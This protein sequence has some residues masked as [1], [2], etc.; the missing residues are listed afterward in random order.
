MFRVGSRRVQRLVNGRLRNTAAEVQSVVQEL[1]SSNVSLPFSRANIGPFFQDQPRLDNQF[2][3]DITLKT[4]LKRHVPK[5]FLA[6]IETDLELFGGRVAT[7]I[8]DLSLRC[9]REPPYLEHFDAW[10]KRID[11][12]VTSPAW[13]KLH[14]ISA[15][16]GLIAIA[17][18]RKYA[19]WSRLYQMCKLY[20]FFPSSGLY[21]C[22]L[23]MTDGAA[24]IIESI[25][26]K[27]PWLM[28]RAYRRLTSRDPSQFW[29]S[30]Q[31]MTERKGG[32][33]V[34]GG[35][36]TVAK[37]QPDGS[38]TLHGY[39]WF[40]SAN[41]SDMA[42]TL[43]RPLDDDGSTIMGTKG[44]SLFYLE[45]NDENGNL[46][47]IEVQ[48]LKNKLGTRQLPT[49]E[50]LLD[51]TKAFKVSEDGRGTAAISNMLMLTRI[52]NTTGAAASMRRI[53][54]L[55]RDYS[56]RRQ[57]FGNVLKNYPLHVQTL[58]R[59]EVETRAACLMTFEVSRLLGREDVDVASEHE[60]QLLRLLTPLAKLYTG[61]QCME[62]V[63][64]GLESFGGQGYIEDTDLPKLLRDCQVLTI[65]EGTTNIL[66]LDVLRAIA[67]SKGKALQSFHEDIET[68]LASAADNG[69]L[70]T[71][72]E[73]VRQA[74]GTILQFAGKNASSLEFA[75]RDFAY[76]LSRTYM[77]SLLIEQAAS[78]YAS[79]SDVYTA[80]R[81]CEK[82]LTPVSSHFSNSAYTQDATDSN[83]SLVFD[84]YLHPSRL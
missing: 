63:S 52:H 1:N 10:G 33:D 28:E 48:K 12:L 65:W 71:A 72:A 26:D 66:S 62:V 20:L 84:G 78:S 50:L 64:E 2:T 4:Y 16:E 55:A 82:D 42:F 3:Q 47:N 23:A 35:T 43:A 49:A 18:E 27:T 29:T 41:D 22:P 24:K 9:E 36:E 73:K 61:K 8:Y 32:S 59:M 37:L 34:A 14:D 81:W 58:A 67:K 69:D 83:F 75:A 30:G 77:G 6:E 45:V 40:S 53:V 25:Q 68:K 13:Q 76:S 57:A 51:G 17:Y 80:Q 5:Q 19:E 15:E 38:Y 74:S 31:W 46:N 11:C 56:T 70:K 79:E 60:K 39:K 21:S 54:N 7:D 44:L